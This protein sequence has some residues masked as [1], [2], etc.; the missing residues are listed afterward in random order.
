D[1]PGANGSA[2]GGAT[3]GVA[4]RGPVCGGARHDDDRALPPADP[5]LLD[6]SH[7]RESARWQDREGRGNRAPLPALR[8]IRGSR[9]LV[10]PYPGLGAGRGPAPGGELTFQSVARTVDSARGSR[11]LRAGDPAASSGCPRVRRERLGTHPARA[12]RLLRVAA[13]ERPRP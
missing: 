1:R 12:P 4:R 10:V 3:V 2:G 8:S 5:R 6:A 9:L 13:P 11:G 7:L